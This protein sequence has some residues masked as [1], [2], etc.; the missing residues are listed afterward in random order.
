M[1]VSE[2]SFII[3]QPPGRTLSF[4]FKPLE[5]KN[6]GSTRHPGFQSPPGLWNIISRESRTKPLFVTGI[7]VGGQIQV[8]CFQTLPLSNNL[9]VVS[10]STSENFRSK[11]II[12]LLVEGQKHIWRKN[13]PNP[14][15]VGSMR[16]AFSATL[17]VETNTNTSVG[18]ETGRMD[19]IGKV[20]GVCLRGT[21]GSCNQC[22]LYRRSRQKENS[23]LSPLNGWRWANPLKWTFQFQAN[24]AKWFSVE[25]VSSCA[26]SFPP[27]CSHS[28][29]LKH[30]AMTSDSRSPKIQSP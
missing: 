21:N 9:S 1:N 22:P 29:T 20:C 28:Q 2:V 6:V 11:S 30:Q 10:E 15:P 18:K 8:V 7:L 19:A 5:L 23:F 12:C 27:T 3:K 14:S 24:P 16:L 26:P 25:D 13:H 4:V 17:T